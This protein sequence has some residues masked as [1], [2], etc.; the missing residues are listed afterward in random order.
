M[1][2]D[3]DAND[4][5]MMHR[6]FAA[7]SREQRFVVTSAQ[8]EPEP[9]LVPVNH[10]VRAVS[11]YTRTVIDPG[12]T[13]VWEDCGLGEYRARRHTHTCPVCEKEH[14][15]LDPDD[16]CW[17]T[18]KLMRRCLECTQPHYTRGSVVLLRVGPALA[19]VCWLYVT[20]GLQQGSSPLQSY[21]Y[22]L[23]TWGKSIPTVSFKH[24]VDRL[25]FIGKADSRLLAFIDQH[26]PY[27]KLS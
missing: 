17:R 10:A 25:H 14:E 27:D 13:C 1:I 9:V 26:L 2:T 3:D 18:S 15:C 23:P 22:A 7:Y 24:P 20:L 6:F 4:W 19:E 8:S 21:A 16:A 5:V 11:G 12:E